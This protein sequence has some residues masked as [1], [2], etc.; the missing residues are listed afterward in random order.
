MIAGS[1]G[2]IGVME[3]ASGGIWTDVLDHFGLG[4]SA[5]GPAFAMQ[6]LFV[7]P[8]LLFGGQLLQKLGL[9]LMLVFGAVLI[10]AASF[11]FISFTAWVI[12]FAIFVFRGAGVALLDLAANTMAMHVEREDNVH[13]MGIVHGGFSVGIVIGSLAAFAIYSLG[14]EFNDV[15]LA[16]ALAMLALGVAL[17]FGPIPKLDAADVV[18]PVTTAAFRMRMVRICAVL[19]GIAFGSEVLISQFVSVLLRDRT[20]ASESFA[21]LSVVVYATMMAIGRFSNS[22][23][24]RRFDPIAVLLVQSIGVAIGGVVLTLSPNASITLTGSFIGGLAIAGIVPTVLSYAAA[25][26]PGSPGET[27]SASLLGGYAGGL[28]LPLLAG[29]L[30]SL[31]SIRAGI[32]LVM[33][34]GVLMA[35]LGVALRQDAERESRTGTL[36]G[37]V[38]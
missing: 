2:A 33:L 14:G 27:A 10:A 1:L 37:G 30:T 21:V 32:A 19:L 24:L 7:L 4:D 34:G 8:V 29:G 17:F 3:G 11:G 23:F 5:L 6:A 13:I 35:Y 38:S 9:R 25:H 22:Y 26:A 28:L 18:E 15:H 20:D 36:P 31:F 16:L 12:F